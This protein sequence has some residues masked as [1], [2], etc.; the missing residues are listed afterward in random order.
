MNQSECKR[1][2]P[3]EW[4]L[5]EG[6]SFMRDSSDD[7]FDLATYHLH[8]SDWVPDGSPEWTATFV[9]Q[10]ISAHARQ[11][12]AALK[13]PLI[14]EEF[15]AVGPHRAALYDL[16][17]DLVMSTPVHAGMH[18]WQLTLDDLRL[19]SAKPKALAVHRDSDSD[20]VAILR[21]HARDMDISALKLPKLD[22]AAPSQAS[23]TLFSSLVDLFSLLV[24]LFSSLVVI[25]LVIACSILVPLVSLPRPRRRLHFPHRTR[26]PI[27]LLT[28]SAEQARWSRR[29]R[30][31]R[32][33]SRH[34][35]WAAARRTR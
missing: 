10:F 27:P 22:L 35:W 20:V 5:H 33:W 28:N 8:D 17:T 14:L 25:F 4:Y 3:T 12:S 18:I 9:R 7:A 2:N 32:G 21:Q 34:R 6:V 26:R 29:P 13:K 16:A 24:D 31:R 15:S 19:D 23:T 1:L 11:A 30:S